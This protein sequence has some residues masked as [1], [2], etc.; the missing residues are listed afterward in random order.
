[1]GQNSERFEPQKEIEKTNISIGHSVVFLSQEVKEDF[2]AQYGIGWAR[3][4][5][6]ILNGRPDGTYDI[7]PGNIGN[8]N[9]IGSSFVSVESEFLIRPY[10][11]KCRDAFLAEIPQEFMR[12]I[13]ATLTNI[14]GKDGMGGTHEEY[15][16]YEKT[17]GITEE[18]D[19]KWLDLVQFYEGTLEEEPSFLHLTDGEQADV[20][21]FVAN[22]EEHL[23]FLMGLSARLGRGAQ[24]YP[25]PR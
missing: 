23:A 10:S 19:N 15:A 21:R 17:Y 8:E 12:L 14:F 18:E 22:K 11:G 2:V 9:F 24:K 13:S 1:V 6:R 20:L 4:I 25:R 5:N 7:I 16:W 3:V